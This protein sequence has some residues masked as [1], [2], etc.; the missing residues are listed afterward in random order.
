MYDLAEI[1][2]QQQNN[3]DL[4]IKNQNVFSH[5]AKEGK[6][7]LERVSAREHH[8]TIRRSILNSAILQH[9]INDICRRR[10]TKKKNRV[11]EDAV[12]I[13]KTR[14]QIRTKQS[15]RMRELRNVNSSIPGALQRIRVKS[16]RKRFEHIFNE[17]LP[18]VITKRESR[19]IMSNANTRAAFFHGSMKAAVIARSERKRK[20]L[21]FANLVAAKARARLLHNQSRKEKMHLSTNEFA[22]NLSSQIEERKKRMALH[23]KSKSY[24][25]KHVIPFAR[26]IGYTK[27]NQLAERKTNQDNSQQ[28]IHHIKKDIQAA[29]DQYQSIAF[30]RS[31]S[32]KKLK[33]VSSMAAAAAQN[34]NC[35]KNKRLI[36]QQ[37]GAKSKFHLNSVIKYAVLN[38]QHNMKQKSARKSIYTESVMVQ[39]KK[40]YIG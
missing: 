32:I 15:S 33:V 36:Q 29:A 1:F 12:K 17:L 30:A 25:S 40:E 39:L 5:A 18:I 28:I 22:K 16:Y 14:F 19:T 6:R 20:H 21:H 7:F 9:S 26:K 23:G 2:L 4:R 10:I 27:T 8:F 35:F 24:F 37:E 11:V 34:K 13:L 38:R 3:I 31:H